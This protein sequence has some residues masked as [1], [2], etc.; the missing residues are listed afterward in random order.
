MARDIKRKALKRKKSRIEEKLDIAK[1]KV[2][3]RE[4]LLSV[5]LADKRAEQIIFIRTPGSFAHLRP[6]ALD[7]ATWPQ[8]VWFACWEI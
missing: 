7:G 4:T 2:T 1:E 3:R 5:L 8:L 6:D